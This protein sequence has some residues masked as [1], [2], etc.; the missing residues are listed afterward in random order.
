MFYSPSPEVYVILKVVCALV[1]S[2][3]TMVF[4]LYVIKSA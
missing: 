2:I 3:F 4:S 1:L